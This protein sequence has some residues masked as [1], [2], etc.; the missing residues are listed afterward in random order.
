MRKLWELKPQI[1]V[2][3]FFEAKSPELFEKRAAPA[4]APSFKH[5]FIWGGRR[6][7]FSSNDE[8]FSEEQKLIFES[9]GPPF[10]LVPLGLG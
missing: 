5:T 6:C 2:G 4:T 8:E 1:E 9:E 3:Q 10:W 7:G